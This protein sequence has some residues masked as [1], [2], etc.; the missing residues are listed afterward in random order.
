LKFK[1]TIKTLK[2]FIA[3]QR[4]NKTVP[5]LLVIKIIQTKLKLNAL[6]PYLPN[7]IYFLWCPREHWKYKLP[8]FPIAGVTRFFGGQSVLGTWTLH[9]RIGGQKDYRK[10]YQ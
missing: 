8:S 2:K 1:N 7:K 6:T 9:F 5:V 4:T 3:A 10:I